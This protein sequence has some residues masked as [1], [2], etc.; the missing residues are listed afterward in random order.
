M[1]TTTHCSVTTRS[2]RH[3]LHSQNTIVKVTTPSL[4]P[5]LKHD[6]VDNP[7]NET[8]A[9][10]IKRAKTNNDTILKDKLREARRMHLIRFRKEA[11]LYSRTLREGKDK[12]TLASKQSLGLA[13]NDGR[14]YLELADAL[15]LQSEE[16]REARDSD[17][18]ARVETR[19]KFTAFW[20]LLL[21]LISDPQKLP[22]TC[23]GCDGGNAETHG[24]CAPHCGTCFDVYCEQNLIGKHTDR[25][26]TCEPCSY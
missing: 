18:D 6:K 12:P 13:V 19:D 9:I 4:R 21:S 5:D 16:I 17:E 8:Y 10:L 11:A 25:V 2:S 15:V 14:T 20:S 3:Y 1:P 23:R 7:N 26:R 22:K 24:Y